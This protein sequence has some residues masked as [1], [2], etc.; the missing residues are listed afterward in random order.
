MVEMRVR[1]QDVL[2]LELVIGGDQPF[3]AEQFVLDLVEGAVLLRCGEHR[4]DG[5]L[6]V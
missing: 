2:H 4:V 1:E 3:E 6:L 5:L